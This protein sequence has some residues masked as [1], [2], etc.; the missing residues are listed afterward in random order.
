MMWQAEAS[1]ADLNGRAGC[2]TS[3]RWP[4]SWWRN[5]HKRT[6]RRTR[7]TD[8]THGQRR[9]RYRE[10]GCCGIVVDVGP[11]SPT[12]SNPAACLHSK[13]PQPNLHPSD[14]NKVQNHETGKR[15]TRITFGSTLH[16]GARVRWT[17]SSPHRQNRL[18]C[19]SWGKASRGR[20]TK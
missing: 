14:L 9:S 1:H 6:T 8:G 3:P 17:K 4:S 10:R 19:A 13:I 20:K 16:R 2:S 7:R 15:K 11:P 5:G 12:P 18:G